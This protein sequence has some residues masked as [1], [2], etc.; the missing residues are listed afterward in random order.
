MRK[1]K[2]C[3]RCGKTLSR[4]KWIYSGIANGELACCPNCNY[5]VATPDGEMPKLK[6]GK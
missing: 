1:Y 4:Y 3:P 5:C 2:K 6:G